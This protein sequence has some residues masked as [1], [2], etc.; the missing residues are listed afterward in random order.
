VKN[1]YHGGIIVYAVVA[2]VL[3]L[4]TLW[5]TPKPVETAHLTQMLTIFV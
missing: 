2:V 4:F 5:V 1:N 3:A